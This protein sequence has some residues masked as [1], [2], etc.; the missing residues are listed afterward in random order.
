MS[1]R[2]FQLGRREEV[3]RRDVRSRQIRRDL[4]SPEQRGGSQPEAGEDE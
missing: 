2:T 4:R 3:T 1:I